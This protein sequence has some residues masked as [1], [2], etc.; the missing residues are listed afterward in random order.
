M[1]VVG[2]IE[3]K[4]MTAAGMIEVK[5]V[6]CRNDLDIEIEYV[7]CGNDWNEINDSSRND[8]S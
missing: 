5:Y 7:C 2:M 1:F 3:M 4:Q 6:C 8:W